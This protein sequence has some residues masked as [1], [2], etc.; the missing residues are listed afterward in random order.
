MW[1]DEYIAIIFKAYKSNCRIIIADVDLIVTEN[2]KDEC[3]WT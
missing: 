1:K 2:R 3:Y